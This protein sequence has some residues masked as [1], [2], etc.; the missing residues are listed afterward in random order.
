MSSWQSQLGVHAVPQCLGQVHAVGAA[1]L[2]EAP[3]WETLDQPL[4]DACSCSPPEWSALNNNIVGEGA[5]TRQPDERAIRAQTE[6][7]VRMALTLH[8]QSMAA[9]V[10]A[11]RVGQHNPPP[12]A[13][14]PSGS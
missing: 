7:L 14:G 5:N 13:A 3:A 1:P 4:H 9:M 8:Q 11:E 6:S 10:Q 12:P 2:C